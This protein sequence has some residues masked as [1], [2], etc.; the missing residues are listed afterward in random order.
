MKTIHS[1]KKVALLVVI[2]T[3][4]SACF[5]DNDKP[6]VNQAPNAESISV[7]T[8]TEV[9]IVDSLEA[10]DPENDPLTFALADSAMF[11]EVS[12]TSAGVFS[13]QPFNEI[14]G[15]DSFTY[16]VSDNAGNT[17]SGTVSI[18]INALEVSARQF[19]RNVFAADESDEPA[20]VNG[21]VF[22]QDSVDQADFQDLLDNN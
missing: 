2:S 8:Q 5:D 3:S 7:T 6:K 17:A 19:A 16:T 14:T 22:I 9:A 11:G 13:Y 1:M 20:R 18:E 10:S 12:I 4:L 21:R 15:S